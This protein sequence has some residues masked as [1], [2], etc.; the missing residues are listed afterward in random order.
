M[1]LQL[2]NNINN[3]SAYLND[4]EKKYSEANKKK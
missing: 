3:L 4:M 2:Q 1:E